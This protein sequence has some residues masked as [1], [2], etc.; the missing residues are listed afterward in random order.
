MTMDI[1]MLKDISDS[2][3]AMAE[4][5]MTVAE[6]AKEMAAG[7]KA[8]VDDCA[9]QIAQRKASGVSESEAMN[10]AFDHIKPS[11]AETTEKKLTL[12]ELRAYVAEQ[13]T[14]EKRPKIKAILRKYG[15]DKLTELKEEHYASVMAEVQKL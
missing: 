6:A 1:K 3:N 12:V 13:S 15:A 4:R 9:E 10:E 8:V 11:A 14:P 5:M 7:L 2:A